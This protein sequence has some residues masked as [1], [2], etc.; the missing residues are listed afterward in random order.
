IICYS[1]K[2]I[3][4]NFFEE[5]IM[6]NPSFLNKTLLNS[7]LLIS[8]DL[9]NTIKSLGLNVLKY[10]VIDKETDKVELMVQDDREFL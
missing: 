4:L 1:D 6:V 5:D 9:E 10:G 2:F 7:V 3:F 8:I